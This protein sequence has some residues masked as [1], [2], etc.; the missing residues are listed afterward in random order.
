VVGLCVCCGVC[1][2]FF[3]FFFFCFFVGGGGG[4]CFKAG[5]RA[6]VKE[7]SLLL[8]VILNNFDSP[9]VLPVT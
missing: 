6:M 2:F 8:T 5:L 3:F 1:F 9:L 4:G 7:E